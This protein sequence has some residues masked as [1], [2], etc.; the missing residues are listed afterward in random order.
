MML[1]DRAVPGDRETAQTLLNRALES[2][3]RIGMPRHVEMTQ[4]LLDRAASR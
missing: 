3:E 4:R 2:Y 1:M